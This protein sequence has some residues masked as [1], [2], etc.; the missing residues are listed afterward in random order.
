M[1]AEKKAQVREAVGI[2]TDEEHLRAA[3]DELQQ[4]H[5]PRHAISV[6]SNEAEM[7][8]KQGKAVI[9][10]YQNQ[11][12]ANVPR[13][14]P[15]MPEERSLLRAVLI[16]GS[17]LAGMALI[18]MPMMQAEGVTQENI[19]PFAAIGGLIGLAVG[20]GLTVLQRKWEHAWMHRRMRKGGLLLWVNTSTPAQERTAR[21]IFS[22]HGAQDVHVHDVV[23]SA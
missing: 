17:A 19:L 6:V 23:L 4:S 20:F 21:R 18:G 22:K 16:G 14:V 3:I 13:G 9:N 11:D 7:R 5:F 1:K 2:F 12:N 8:W 15:I 10:P